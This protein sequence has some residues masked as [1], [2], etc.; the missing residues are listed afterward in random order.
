MSRPTFEQ[1]RSAAYTKL[2]DAADEIRGGH[3]T[4]APT[5]DQNAAIRHALDL[6]GKAKDALNDA[7]HR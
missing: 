5:A 4:P 2:S 6:I 7:A 3:W 1:S